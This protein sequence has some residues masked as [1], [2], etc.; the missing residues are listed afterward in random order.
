LVLQACVGV[1]VRC[2][3]VISAQYTSCHGPPNDV[4]GQVE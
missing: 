4:G 1:I 3:T 2:L